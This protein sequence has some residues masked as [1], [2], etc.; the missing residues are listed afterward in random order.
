ML[1]RFGPDGAA[2]V[3]DQHIK[4]AEML[5]RRSHYPAALAVLFKIGGQTQHAL[6]LQFMHQLRAIHG[7]QRRAFCKQTLAQTTA[8]PLRRAGNQRDLVGESVHDNL[9]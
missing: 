2:N 5:H 4:A 3:V 6:A 7:H 9:E 8:D 1:E